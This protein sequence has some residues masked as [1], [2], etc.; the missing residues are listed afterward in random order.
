M[1]SDDEPSAWL[2]EQLDDELAGLRTRPGAL[3]E[4][5]DRARARE[6]WWR[7]VGPAGVPAWFVAAA[8]VLVVALAVPILASTVFGRSGPPDR[9]ASRAL[10]Q[11]SPTPLVARSPVPSPSVVPSTPS[12]G[13]TAPAR[14]KETTAVPPPPAATIPSAT[15]ATCGKPSNSARGSSGSTPGFAADLDGD[16]QPDEVSALS[17]SLTVRLTTG[18]TLLAPFRTASPYVALLPVETDGS[19]GGELLVVTRGG[20]G[21]DG[22]VGMN[23]V[24]YDVRG[25]T[26]GPLLNAQGKPYTFEIG[27]SQSDT[28]R[29]GVACDGPV[30]LGVTSVRDASGSWDVTSTPVTSTDGNAVNG[31]PQHSTLADGA[32]GTD[33]LR[34]AR[35]GSATPQSLG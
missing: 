9:L 13:P 29:A 35:C 21:N 30:L 2:R 26:F 1:S 31:P 24:L 11:P 28:R 17:G 23:G 27:S 15:P 22:S 12:P 16:G 8:A 19:A 6:P 10:P 4:V 34:E 25:C 3:R 32:G 14:A 7:R 33:A 18:G 20:I 5:L